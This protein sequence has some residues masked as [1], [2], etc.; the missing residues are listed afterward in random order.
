VFNVHIAI[1]GNPRRLPIMQIKDLVI[2]VF[3][4]N[5]SLSNPPIKVDIKP[6]IAI[7]ADVYKP[8]SVL[9]RG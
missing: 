8:Y 3:F 4:S 2:L 1:A 5:L 9:K 7:I 6:Q